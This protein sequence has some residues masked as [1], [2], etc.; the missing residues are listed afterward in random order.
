[1]KTLKKGTPKCTETRILQG[2][3]NLHGIEIAVDGSFGPGTQL[4]VKTFQKQNGLVADGIAGPATQRA[5]GILTAANSKIVTIKIPFTAITSAGLIL[6]DK[7]RCSFATLANSS[8]YNFVM[9][10]PMFDTKTYAVVNDIVMSGK[11]INGGNYSNIG[12]AFNKAKN[13]KKIFRSRTADCKGKMV[14]FTGASPTLIVDGIKYMDDKGLSKAY[15]NQSTIWNCCGCD[16]NAFYYM[17][18]LS[19]VKLNDMAVEGQAQGIKTLI[20]QDGGGSRALSICKKIVLPTDGRAI[21]CAI[22]L[23]IKL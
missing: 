18:C 2:L 9:N 14:D 10:G 6:K 20:N 19:K 12:I 1:M 7:T 21:P 22:G 4:A 15:L 13:G 5:L 23:E 3:L 17:T 11:V 16:D 8:D